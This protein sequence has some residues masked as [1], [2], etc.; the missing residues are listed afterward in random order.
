MQR[1]VIKQRDSY[2]VTLPMKWVKENNAPDEIEVEESKDGNIII[3][4]SSLEKLRSISINIEKEKIRMVRSYIA[5]L[6]RMGYTEINVSFE[7]KDMI[8]QLQLLVESFYGMDI[9]NIKDDSC[10]IKTVSYVEP[11]EIKQHIMKMAYIISSMFDMI[12]EDIKQKKKNSFEQILQF[13]NNCYK[14]RDIIHRTITNINQNDFTIFPYYLIS[15]NVSE[16]AKALSQMYE[17]IS[18]GKK[19]E[20][21]LLI[22]SQDLFRKLFLSK[23][24]FDFELH[25]NK[26]KVM[27]EV[28]NDLSKGKSNITTA[29]ILR[30]VTAIQ[31]CNAPFTMIKLAKES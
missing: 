26:N 31:Y 20:T 24:E 17:A 27:N 13:R 6:Y 12:I 3:S 4:T 23:T 18:P 28:N 16:I 30:I 8:H 15:H 22:Q 29:Y 1:K 14:Q 9:F 11:K 19:I 2:T 5:S 10:T 21:K 7:S 25:S